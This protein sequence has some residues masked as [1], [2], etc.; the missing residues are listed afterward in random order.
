MEAGALAGGGEQ[1][2]ATAGELD[3]FGEAGE[4]E[5]IVAGEGGGRVE[6][7]AAVGDFDVEDGIAGG[8]GDSGGGGAGVTGDVGEGFL[9]NAVGGDFERSGE[10]FGGKREFE[11]DEDAS[12]AAEVF[13]VGL[14]GGAQ[15]EIVEEAR[16]ELEGEGADGGEEFVGDGEGFGEGGA[17]GVGAG[18]FE[19]K[20]EAGEELADLIVEL[21]G[22]GVTLVFLHAEEAGGEGLGASGLGGGKLF[23]GAADDD[24]GFEGAG[25]VGDL[26]GEGAVEGGEFVGEL[27]GEAGG[28]RVAEGVGEGVGE[29]GETAGAVDD[30]VVGAELEGGD[31]GFA[32]VVA[33]EDEDRDGFVVGAELAEGVEERG[34]FVVGSED[35]GV[36]GGGAAEEIFERG[37]G[38]GGE[39]EMGGFGGEEFRGVVAQHG[40]AIE[41]KDAGGEWRRR[42]GDEVGAAAVAGD[43]VLGDLVDAAKLRG[44]F[45]EAI[46]GA[47]AEGAD[48]EFGLALAAD[49][50]DG[51]WVA[52][53]GEFTED[54]EAVAV[55]HREIKEE[56]IVAA[57][58][59][60]GEAL[61]AGGDDGE[62]GR[63]VRKKIEPDNV[64]DLR[65]VF[66]VE[67]TGHGRRIGSEIDPAGGGLEGNSRR[68]DY[69][70][71]RMGRWGVVGYT[72]GINSKAPN[73]ISCGRRAVAETM[74]LPH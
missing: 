38:S 35:D 61:L 22:E 73:C 70:W 65:I 51:R 33:G 9:D 21:V 15:A 25:A 64:R 31:G 34:D 16:A 32:G 71:T 10:T 26:V 52:V 12:L 44:V 68:P 3:T 54:L 6:A 56:E 40:I 60:L 45:I 59:H 67:H 53:G 63:G 72:A 48:G 62:L 24:F 36:E 27:G 74:I 8:G 30:V 50:D 23:G 55:G 29:F 66:G 39:L 49:H 17:G 1:F 41:K 2:K 46:G 11:C 47:R 13:E 58:R 42:G 69:G 20:A 4:A 19:L 14:Q 18:G 5:G 43:G 7:A 57:A 28:G 37:R